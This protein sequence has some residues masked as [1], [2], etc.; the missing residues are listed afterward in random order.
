MKR[1]IKYKDK[2]DVQLH[3]GDIVRVENRTGII[4]T[5]SNDK[6][7]CGCPGSWGYELSEFVKDDIMFLGTKKTRPFLFADV[8]YASDTFHVNVP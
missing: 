2:D 3:V 8:F 6:V 1:K 5:A 7:F 4:Y